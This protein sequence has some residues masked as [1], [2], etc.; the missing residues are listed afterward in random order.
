MNVLRYNYFKC[1]RVWGR[2]RLWIQYLPRFLWWGG[3]WLDKQEAVLSNDPC[4]W[5]LLWDSWFIF[6]R[7]LAINKKHNIKLRYQN[8]CWYS[9]SAKYMDTPNKHTHTHSHTHTHKKTLPYYHRLWQHWPGCST[10][11]PRLGLAGAEV[12]VPSPL[13]GRGQRQTGCPAQGSQTRGSR[14][15]WSPVCHCL[16]CSQWMGFEGSDRTIR[17]GWGRNESQLNVSK[18]RPLIV[19][20][21]AELKNVTFHQ[22]WSITVGEQ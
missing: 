6:L 18:N 17:R 15:G 12:Q 20:T 11:G 13:S 21:P 4:V 19:Q 8:S 9:V 16:D 7:T 14:L 5:G 10:L 1:V 3:Q 22:L 2:E